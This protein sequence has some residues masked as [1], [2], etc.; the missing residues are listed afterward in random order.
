MSKLKKKNP[1]YINY[2]YRYKKNYYNNNNN[3]R[4]IY[5]IQNL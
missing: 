1:I 4:R 5:K 3:S 2:R